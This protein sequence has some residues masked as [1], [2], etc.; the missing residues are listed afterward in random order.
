MSAATTLSGRVRSSLKAA[1]FDG[2]SVFRSGAPE[3]IRTPDPQIRSLRFT[4]VIS[5]D[6]HSTADFPLE[7]SIDPQSFIVIGRQEIAH[8][9]LPFA[10]FRRPCALHSQHVGC[11]LV[12]E[13]KALPDFLGFRAAR[14]RYSTKP[15]W[16]GLGRSVSN[17]LPFSMCPRVSTT[18]NQS[19]FLTVLLACA[20]A[21]P[22]ASS[23]LVSD[24]PTISSTL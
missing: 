22:I 21:V 13:R 15:D 6:K 7:L 3:E 1:A 14:F 17:I 16:E 2:D 8:S 18:S 10:Y 5:A 20:T 19:I 24:E 12:A 11:P 23:M 4:S 9:C